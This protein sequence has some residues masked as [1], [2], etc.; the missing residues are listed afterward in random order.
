MELLFHRVCHMREQKHLLLGVKEAEALNQTEA[1]VGAARA[2]K[3]AC[4]VP[5]AGQVVVG[6]FLVTADRTK[7]NA[8]DGLVTNFDAE[9]WDA[10]MGK[11]LR[12]SSDAQMLV[13]G[14]CERC[15]Q[16]EWH[17]KPIDFE[18]RPTFGN[19]SLGESG[20]MRNMVAAL[21]WLLGSHLAHINQGTVG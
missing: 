16:W 21:D 11:K 19:L 6:Q 18:N 4:N 1:S 15:P 10:R 14:Q 7:R 3:G 8:S 2:P 12:S 17:H 9:V 5:F 13:V 20:E